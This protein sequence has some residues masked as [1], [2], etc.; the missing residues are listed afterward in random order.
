MSAGNP[1]Q[2]SNTS[3]AV[4]TMSVGNPSQGSTTSH[5][6]R[7]MSA[8]YFSQPPPGLNHVARG[9]WCSVDRHESHLEEER[10]V[11]GDKPRNPTFAVGKV[12]R[13]D[14]A[15]LLA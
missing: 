7:A 2:G 8:Y 3:H 13:H 10:G 6:V 5:A 11:G 14:D 9:A 15:C 4:R 1:S 12:R